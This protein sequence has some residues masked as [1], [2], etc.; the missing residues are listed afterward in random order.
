MYDETMTSYRENPIFDPCNNYIK[1]VSKV[2]ADKRMHI[3]KCSFV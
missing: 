1:F 2:C 3:G